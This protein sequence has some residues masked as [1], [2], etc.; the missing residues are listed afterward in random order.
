MSES[1]PSN[2]QSQNRGPFGWVTRELHHAAPAIHE[3]EQI[4]QDV[5]P[6]AEAIDPALKPLFDEIARLEQQLAAL[7]QQQQQQQPAPA[8]PQ[9]VQADGGHYPPVELAPVQQPDAA[10]ASAAH[11]AATAPSHEPRGGA[12][13]PD[14]ITLL[15]CPA[16]NQRV[17][18]NPGGQAVDPYAATDCGEQSCAMVT[19]ACDHIEL[20]EETIRGYIRDH[21]GG[22]MQDGRTTADD[23]AWYLSSEH[24]NFPHARSLTAEWPILHEQIKQHILSGYLP[25][26]LGEFYAGA[27]HWV[28]GRGADQTWFC[29]NDPWTGTEKAVTW[30]ELAAIQQGV[31]VL[32]F[33][34]AQYA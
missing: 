1:S 12:A 10:P 17:D 19:Y 34:R 33:G 8:A 6:I 2:S 11:E 21:R 25:I 3:A 7:Q 32:T 30:D 13:V 24:S 5:A 26:V 14:H 4:E 31:A 29:Y 23:L 27:L 15:A 22:D 16:W 9:P 20:P 28:V 18:D